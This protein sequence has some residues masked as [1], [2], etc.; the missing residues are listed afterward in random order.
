MKPAPVDGEGISVA[1][2][3]R[4]VIEYRNYDLPLQFPIIA[5]TGDQWHISHIPSK[6]LH[7]HNCLEIG[8]CHSESG[9]IVFENTPCPFRAGD[10][11][12]IARNVPHTTYS[13]DEN[14]SMWSYLLFQPEALLKDQLPPHVFSDRALDSMLRNSHMILPQ[15]EY[16]GVRLLVHQIIRE[17]EGKARGYQLSVRCLCAALILNLLRAYDR[18]SAQR[19]KDDGAYAIVIAPALDYVHL[20]YAQTFPLD[21]LAMECHL[22]PAHFRRIFS[23]TMKLS[24]LGFLHQTRVAASCTLLRTTDESIAGIAAKVGYSTPSTY[25]RHFLSIMGCSPSE[26][27]KTTAPDEKP[28]IM[29]YTGW[30]QAEQIDDD[31]E[32]VSMN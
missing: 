12:C 27:R 29:E 7:F 2:T 21:T 24:P 30:L 9:T 14:K 15:S 18:E 5:L 6:R 19:P 10:V 28:L 3:K 32:P 1:R 16:P 8:Y 11:T 4:T 31:G 20:H 23:A 22:S 26:Y 17:M 13:S 25:N